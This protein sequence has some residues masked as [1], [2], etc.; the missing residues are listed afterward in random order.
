[1]RLDG[2]RRVFLPL[3]LLISLLL[4][5]VVAWSSLLRCNAVATFLANRAWL[6]SGK[7]TTRSLNTSNAFIPA[8]D[9]GI[10]V[11]S[12]HPFSDNGQAK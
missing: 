1:M 11:C 4:L 8:N 9:P 10:H 5:A 12:D 7:A 6:V 3:T 2:S